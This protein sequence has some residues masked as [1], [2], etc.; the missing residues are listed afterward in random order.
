VRRS[1]NP[2]RLNQPSSFDDRDVR[3]GRAAGSTAGT[4]VSGGA[5]RAADGVA[6]ALVPFDGDFY[7]VS[8]GHHDLMAMSAWRQMFL[9]PM[10]A[11]PSQNAMTVVSTPACSW[12][13][14]SH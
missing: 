4:L 8:P 2:D 10:S 11:G 14:R 5:E 7:S 3:C 1:A 12:I 9:E 13:W 6:A